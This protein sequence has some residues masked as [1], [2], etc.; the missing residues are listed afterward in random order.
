VAVIH[1][2]KMNLYE[3]IKVC[4]LIVAHN[5]L[6]YQRVNAWLYAIKKEY[7]SEENYG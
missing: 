3:A 7:I 1:F 2:G 4:E 6:E 5:P